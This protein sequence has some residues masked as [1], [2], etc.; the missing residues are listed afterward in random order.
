MFCQSGKHLKACGSIFGIYP[1]SEKQLV[2]EMLLVLLFSTRSFAPYFDRKRHILR[3]DLKNLWREQYL[4]K[5][6]ETFPPEE[7]WSPFQISASYRGVIFSW[8]YASANL[9]STEETFDTKGGKQEKK[10][11]NFPKNRRNN[12]IGV[13]M[14][15]IPEELLRTGSESRAYHVSI[16]AKR[17][18]K[19]KRKLN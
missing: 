17:K 15:Q 12:N 11:R 3:R 7:T 6:R 18:P 8:F 14:A 2:V 19:E 13:K 10:K 16:S 1:E 4:L 9:D 5:F